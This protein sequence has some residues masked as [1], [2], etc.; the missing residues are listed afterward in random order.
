[1][2]KQ[3]I[4]ALGNMAAHPV[5]RREE[6]AADCWPAVESRTGYRWLR[7]SAGYSV[8]SRLVVDQSV[9]ATEPAAGLTAQLGDDLSEEAQHGIGSVRPQG[10]DR[11]ADHQQQCRHA[12][13]LFGVKV[14]G[15]SGRLDRP[16]QLSNRPERV[17]STRRS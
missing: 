17:T 7:S 9:A 4:R 5:H 12:M 1:M 10:V 16:G 15:L 6:V 2:R 13:R 11:V 3:A 14:P 8:S